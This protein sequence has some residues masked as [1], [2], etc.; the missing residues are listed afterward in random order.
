MISREKLLSQTAKRYVDKIIF[1]E[2]YR[3][4]SLSEREKADYEIKLQDKKSGMSTKKARAL[5]LCRVL[6]D[7]SNNRL[8][9]DED[10]DAVGAMDG[11]IASAIYA[12]ALDHNGYDETDIEELVKNSEGATG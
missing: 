4:Q 10:V 11:R 9:R 8:L 5:F 1:G 2:E 3:I 7:E 12:V 6:V